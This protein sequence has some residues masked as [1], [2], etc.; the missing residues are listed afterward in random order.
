LAD[1]YKNLAEIARAKGVSA[2]A[3]TAWSKKH[4]WPRSLDRAAIDAFVQRVVMPHRRGKQKTPANETAAAVPAAIVENAQPA[5][6]Q[7]RTAP[8]LPPVPAPVNCGD[9]ADVETATL[10]EL[11]QRIRR[12]RSSET[13]ERL[14]KQVRALKVVREIQERDGKLIDAELARSEIRAALFALTTGIMSVPAAVAASLEGLDPVSIRTVLEGRFTELLGELARGLK[15]AIDFD[16]HSTEPKAVD[17]NDRGA[18][19]SRETAA[20]PDI[21]AVSRAQP[22]AEQPPG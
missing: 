5:A 4:G 18:E 22:P 11:E 14:S 12:T 10:E 19:G 9:D 7:A 1:R 13:A 2:P 21:G 16:L 6:V 20:E 17:G 8:P 15:R 3:V